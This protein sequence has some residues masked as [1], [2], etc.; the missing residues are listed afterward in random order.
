MFVASYA[1]WVGLFGVIR[2]AGV[3]E[4]LSAAAI[5]AAL[6]ALAPDRSRLRFAAPVVAA[7]LLVA[8]TRCPNWGRVPHGAPAVTARV[9]GIPGDAMV[10]IATLEPVAYIV[11]SLPHEVP[12]VAL[13]NNFL[14]PEPH[15]SRLEEIAQ[16][17]V[18]GHAGPLLLLTRGDAAS[19]RYYSGESIFGMLAQ[20]GLVPDMARCAPIRTGLDPDGLAL[21]EL[22]RTRRDD[23]AR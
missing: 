12:V 18:H 6:A 10:V 21:C 1:S 11:P 22:V 23:P 16:R 20:L 13:V 9:P 5:G 8:G 14:R 3:L 17:R 19:E 7:V 15:P 2:F 4:L